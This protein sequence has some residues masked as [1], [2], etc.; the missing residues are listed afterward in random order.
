VPIYTVGQLTQFL[1][2]FLE[3][4]SFLQDLWVSGEVSNLNVS[5]AGHTYF[6]LK[7]QDGQLRCVMFQGRKGAE[8]VANGN[9][10][11]VHGRVT[12]YRVRGQ[13]ELLADLVVP[14]GTGP[15]HLELE[16]LKLKLEEEGL[17]EESRKR[18]LP[19][20]P[21]TIAVVT[22][23]SGAV[24]H[25]ICHIILRR[26]P[27]VNVVVAPTPVQGDDAAPSIVAAIKA[28]NQETDA[29]VIILAR[30]GGSLEELW[31][32]NTELVARAIYASRIP[33]VS[34]VGHETDYTI[35]DYVADVRAPTPSAAAEMVVP[36]RAALLSQAENLEQRLDVAL[37]GVYSTHRQELQS[38]VHRMYAHL[39]PLDSMKRHLDEVSERLLFV[40][41][42]TVEQQQE[43]VN[44]LV[45]QLNSINPSHVLARGYAL[46][47]KS[48]NN[49][50]VSSVAQVSTGEGLKVTVSDG[51]FP[52]VAGAAKHNKGK[53]RAVTAM[54][55]LL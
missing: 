33:V 55:R 39:P 4:E 25:D 21:K 19:H 37:A 44:A 53:K 30:G 17:F 14:E 50:V 6:T 3:A 43:R 34:A 18:P 15:L 27:L 31:P 45:S 42:T 12:F 1:Q 52:A 2:E 5:S 40:F 46:V 16:R 47:Q 35:A 7:D 8:L 29:D 28:V 48:S 49:H 54:E 10:V 32:F 22:S 20:F 26:Y 51:S 13:L 36:D 41:R 23:P 24:L 11:L 9:A 38:L